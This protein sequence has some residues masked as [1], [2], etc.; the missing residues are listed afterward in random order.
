MKPKFLKP[1][2][3]RAVTQGGGTPRKKPERATPPRLSL[4]TSR[5][6]QSIITQSRVA[7][8]IT[9]SETIPATVERTHKSPKLRTISVMSYPPLWMFSRARAVENL[10]VSSPSGPVYGV[11][12]PSCPAGHDRQLHGKK[13]MNTLRV[14]VESMRFVKKKYGKYP[15]D[16]IYL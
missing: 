11:F 1:A 9:P 6:A 3:S 4:T 13:V 16:F 5:R 12:H 7:A 10:D 15:N 14:S 2:R 8:E